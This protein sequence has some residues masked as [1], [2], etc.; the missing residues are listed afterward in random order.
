MRA[1]RKRGGF[2]EVQVAERGREF[3][4]GVVEISPKREAGE[5]KGKLFDFLVEKGPQ[6]EV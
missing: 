3:V 5:G 1:V 4:D 6:R 2:W